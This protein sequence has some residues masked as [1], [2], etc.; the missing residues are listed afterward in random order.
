MPSRRLL[1]IPALGLALSAQGPEVTTTA[2]DRTGLSIT[3]YYGE[4]A[5]V[6]D[7]RRVTLPAGPSRL[8]F[9]DVA[10][11]IRPKSAWMRFSGDAPTVL[12]RNYEF[13]LLS[14]ASL[15][16][17]SLGA[18][19]GIRME[20]KDE[21]QWGELASLPPEIPRRAAQGGVKPDTSLLVRSG[22]T[23]QAI[24]NTGLAFRD[25]PEQL[26]PSPT[27]LADVH[28][29]GG[30]WTEIEL[31]YT[32]E[33]FSWEVSY[34]A[35]LTPS[36]ASADLDAFVT[37]SNRSGMD[38]PATNLQLV[39]GWVNV[40]EWNESEFRQNSEP[41][42]AFVEVVATARVGFKEESLADFQLLTLER[43]TSLRNGQT[44]QIRLFGVK[45]VPL[46][47]TF[48]FNW[49][50][51]IQRGRPPAAPIG[52][53][54][55][56]MTG[57]RSDHEEIDPSRGSDSRAACEADRPLV[58]L[59]LRNN[60]HSGLGRA[61]PFGT[62]NLSIRGPHGEEVPIGPSWM[63]DTPPGEE[64]ILE[65]P[66]GWLARGVEGS[67]RWRPVA[68]QAEWMEL[69]AESH[70]TNSRGEDA[71]ILLRLQLPEGTEIRSAEVPPTLAAPGV[72][73]FRL[74][75]PPHSERTLRFR[76]RVPKKAL[77]FT[78]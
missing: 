31:A 45:G 37:L 58:L 71:P 29:G 36:G 35:S 20:G 25:V 60:I 76:S 42:E 47:R 51:N 24:P 54:S 50:P 32:A 27:L 55:S 78:Y 69:E 26:R 12:E 38:F 49:R 44:K 21:I 7:T 46:V 43:P 30:R 22:L 39:A 17:H 66:E 34:H 6:R 1:L 70:L 41:R 63:D 2:K 67:H 73:D 3:L 68:W 75:L 13:D 65:V 77:P 53:S 18:P 5:M 56:W 57:A 8:A 14:P 40:E 15:V 72:F 33:Q 59:T 62:V 52:A 48:L 23:Y 64:A 16:R 61:L 28:G 9:A 19:V 11:S 74:T 4:L 10:A